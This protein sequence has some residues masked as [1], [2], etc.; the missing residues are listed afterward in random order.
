M[1]LR[2]GRDWEIG[3][4]QSGAEKSIGVVLFLRLH[5]ARKMGQSVDD[6]EADDSVDEGIGD[7]LQVSLV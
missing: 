6:A 2:H 1:P 5:E 7:H 4:W 3:F